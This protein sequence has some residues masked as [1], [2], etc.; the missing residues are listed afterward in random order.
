MSRKSPPSLSGNPEMNSEDTADRWAGRFGLARVPLFEFGEVEDGG[1]HHMLLDGGY[2]SFALSESQDR[3]YETQTSAEWSWSSN[4]P[5][6]VSVT[7]NHVGVVR[8]DRGDEKL[9]TRSSVERQLDTFY[10]YLVNDKVQSNRRVV[11]YMVTLFRKVRSLVADAGIEDSQSVDAFLGILSKAIVRRTELDD[12]AMNQLG[13]DESIEV[14]KDLSQSG[15]ERAL[16]YCES[17]WLGGNPPLRIHP[18]LAV[19]HAGSEL[20]QE[21][22]FELVR[23][24]DPNLFGD[25]E[26]AKSSGI[27]RGGAHFTPPALARILVE[28]TLDEVDDLRTR[29][30]LVVVDPAC[31]SGVFLHE[32]L[33]TLRRLGYRG[34]V[35]L[36]GWDISSAAVAMARF[37][38]SNALNDWKPEGG[39]TFETR[40]VDSMS[41]PLPNADVVLMNPPFVAWPALTTKQRE[42]VTGVLQS[43]FIGRADLCMAFL[44]KAVRS[45]KRGGVVGSLLPASMLTAEQAGEW[46]NDLLDSA[47]LTFLGTL[48]DFGLFI[49][50][51]VQVAATVFAKRK[52]EERKSGVAIG[53]V[54]SNDRSSTG[55]ALREL[56]KV[57]KDDEPRRD[58]GWQIFQVSNANLKRRPTWRLVPPDT[59]RALTNLLESGRALKVEELFEVRQGVLTGLNSVFL[60]KAEELNELPQSER[61]WFRAAI[62]NDSIKDGTIASTDFVFYPYGPEGLKLR[63]QEEVEEAVPHFYQEYLEPNR[64]RL[65][66]RSGH[67]RQRRE[68]WWGLTWPRT[69]ERVRGPRIATK[70]F[71]GRGGFA[72]DVEARHVVVQGFAWLPKEGTDYGMAIVD[73]SVGI[74][75]EEVLQ[76]Y[77]AVLNSRQFV[78]L[79]GV[80]SPQVAG[81]QFNLSPRFVRHIPLPDLL[82]LWTEEE[83]CETICRLAELGR[84][85]DLFNETTLR[86]IDDLARRLY[87]IESLDDV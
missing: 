12:P 54:S 8:W 70:Y 86:E 43:T 10:H 28:Q 47:E 37:V 71:G 26:P 29:S 58:E 15:V 39:G 38:L 16:E 60:L 27:T 69:W 51:M 18:V 24:S 7:E 33:R 62:T 31:G 68:D 46:R 32:T 48:G 87:G 40:V 9:F 44:T 2:G 45:I 72:P 74:A 22:H 57:G 79:L 73:D 21:A 50:A 64:E 77:A 75:I 1:R 11:D 30:E 59:E 53:L 34:S 80:Y 67:V 63:S 84:G 36:I 81:G 6:H 49:H 23:T 13:F 17:P 66:S 4:V 55:N 83:A 56:R 42:Q 19:R 82:G 14:L 5:H 35:H 3:T 25:F 20:F 85:K 78:R 41:V 52:P 76:A 61:R 65:A